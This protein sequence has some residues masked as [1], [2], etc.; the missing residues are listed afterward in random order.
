MAQIPWMSSGC[1]MR[2]LVSP[3]G[4][5]AYMVAV[6]SALWPRPIVWPASCVMVFC[7]SYA[8]QPTRGPVG[9]QVGP[10]AVVKEKAGS[11]SS[12]SASRISPVE[13]TDVVV[14]VAMA[15]ES[16]SQQSYL[17]EQPPWV[18][19][20]SL[21]GTADAQL[22]GRQRTRLRFVPPGTY[23]TRRSVCAGGTSLNCKSEQLTAAQVAKLRRTAPN[24]LPLER[25][26][27]PRESIWYECPRLAQKSKGPLPFTW[28]RSYAE[29]ENATNSAAKA[30]DSRISARSRRRAGRAPADR[31][32]AGRPPRPPRNRRTRRGSGRA[33]RA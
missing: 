5:K 26:A 25:S 4:A 27:V 33:P 20:G 6:A 11:L 32:R 19:Q 14:V 21:A 8:T 15:L 10:S 24:S 7:T 12:M 28:A 3:T 17:F 13:V 31:R 16:P 1:K 18:R 22:A 9:A 29:A 2:L 23:P 30:A